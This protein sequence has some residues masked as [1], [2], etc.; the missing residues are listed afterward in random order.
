VTLRNNIVTDNLATG[1][2]AG[3]SVSDCGAVKLINNGIAEN[4]NRDNNP[5]TFTGCGGV[6]IYNPGATLTMTNNTF[7]NNHADGE[8]SG[9]CLYLN[10]N[11]DKAYI[12]NNVVWNN[13]ADDCKDFSI[14][15]DGNA[16]YWY[17]PVYLYNN[18]F[19][20][21]E[22]GFCISRP[23]FKISATNLNT[24]PLFFYPDERNYRLTGLS[25]LLDKGK[26]N[27]PARPAKDR[28]G[29]PRIVNSL[30]DMGAYEYNADLPTVTLETTD[31]SAAEPGDKGQ[32]VIHRT[33]DTTAALKVSYLVTGTAANGED[34]QKLS[35]TVTIDAGAKSKALWV[36]PLDDT[37]V[38][39]DETVVVTLRGGVG[40][41]VGI[42]SVGKVVIG[43][44]EGQEQRDRR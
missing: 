6:Q 7:V 24:D 12:Y 1:V 37:L 39:G 38:E 15:S 4:D 34:Y 28:D 19:D 27:A 26:N 3:V 8:G 18:D 2:V 11:E 14:N 25:P 29:N 41:T 5:S 22:T 31:D 16:D 44:D 32:L 10:E 21:S 36:T 13:T 40:Y 20:Q 33:G 9:V 42:G 23:N 43:D 17:S 30:V 35:G